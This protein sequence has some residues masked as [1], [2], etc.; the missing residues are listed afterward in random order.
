MAN[1]CISCNN[2]GH[3]GWS[4]NRGNFLITIVLAF[5]FL[6]PAVIYEIWR[7][8]GLGVCESCGS[9]AVVPSSQCVSNKPSDAGEL[10][11]LLVIGIIGGSV[12]MVLYAMADGAIDAF[13]GRN[14]PPPQLSQRDLEKRCFYDGMSHYQNKNEYPILKDGK[15]LAMDK[16]QFDCKGSTTGKYVAK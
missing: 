11:I 16:I 10:A 12:F 14:D 13:K 9:D 15:T 7:R 8:S 4:K 1:K 3:V 2:C 6:I 5:L